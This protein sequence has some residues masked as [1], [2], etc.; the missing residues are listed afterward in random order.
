MLRLQSVP[1]VHLLPVLILVL[2]CAFTTARAQDITRAP[3]ENDR[4]FATRALHLMGDAEPH[5]TAASWNGVPTLFVDYQTSGEYPERPIAAL[6]RQPSG[7]YHAFQV[8]LG[9][10]EGGTPDLVALG[11]ARADHGSPAKDLIVILAWDVKHATV[12]GTL[13]EVRIFAPPHPGQQALTLLKV[14]E[15]FGSECECTWDDGTS[16]AF[17]FKTIAAVKAELKRLGY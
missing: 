12:S 17:R 8:T 7:G 15:K 3:G 16:K 4:A 2:A 1:R 6:Q 11:F 9:E 13:Y 10:Q 5:V 14:S